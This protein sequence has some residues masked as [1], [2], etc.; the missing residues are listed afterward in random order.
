MLLDPRHI[1]AAL[2]FTSRDETRAMLT[3]VRITSQYVEATDS[4]KLVR[5]TPK[6]SMS[7]EDFPRFPDGSPATGT[8]SERGIL[9]DAKALKRSLRNVPKAR[10]SLP[11]LSRIAVKPSGNHVLLT[12]TDLNLTSS[13]TSR[14]IEGAFP[15]IDKHLP[16]D[17][18]TSTITFSAEFL[19]Q[20]A[21]AF[22]DFGGSKAIVTVDVFSELKPARFSATDDEGTEMVAILMP[23]RKG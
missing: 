9:V 14:L 17:E 4:Y 22:Q 8:I 12:T 1:K 10:R 3:G 20:V 5:I 2:P 18:P 13:E 23:V 7:Q 6:G 21:K 15:E 16:S 11:I 19:K